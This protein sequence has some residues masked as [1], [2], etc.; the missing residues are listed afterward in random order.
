MIFDTFCA[1][2]LAQPDVLVVLGKVLTSKPVGKSI[3]FTCYCSSGNRSQA[4]NPIF[5]SYTAGVAHKVFFS[6]AVFI[7]RQRLLFKFPLKTCCLLN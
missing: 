1:F 5:I 6:T 2:N 4:E 3:Y 7:L